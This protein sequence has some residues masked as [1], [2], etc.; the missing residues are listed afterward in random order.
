LHKSGF[1]ERHRHKPVDSLF[2]AAPEH[3]SRGQVHRQQEWPLLPKT[4]AN[5]GGAPIEAFNQL[6]SGGQADRS[7]LPKGSTR[8]R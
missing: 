5:P 4:A 6:R 7:Q 1:L 3:S 8:V 2:V